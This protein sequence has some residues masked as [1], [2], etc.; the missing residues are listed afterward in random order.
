MS[1]IGLYH[2]LVI[3][4]VLAV[5][6]AIIWTS[7][8]QRVMSRGP[9]ALRVAIFVAVGIGILLTIAFRVS[10]IL[11]YGLMGFYFGLF[12]ALIVWTTQR[13]ADIGWS[14]WWAILI[15]VSGANLILVIILMLKPGMRTPPPQTP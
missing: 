14:R 5:P 15:C 1:G 8:D 13:L 7:R 6:A 12:V 4:L 11:L 10:E 2:Y 3:A 9:Y